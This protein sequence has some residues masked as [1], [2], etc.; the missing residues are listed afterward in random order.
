[1]TTRKKKTKKNAKAV[2]RSLALC[3]HHTRTRTRTRT[4]KKKANKKTQKHS[5]HRINANTDTKLPEADET[6]Q[7][8]KKTRWEEGVARRA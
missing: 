3:I 8:K 6:P 4:R 2:P 7:K 5:P 1:M